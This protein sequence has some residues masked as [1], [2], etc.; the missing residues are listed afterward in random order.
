[1]PKT[2]FSNSQLPQSQS[3]PKF[4]LSGFLVGNS[5]VTVAKLYSPLYL[6][7]QYIKSAMLKAQSPKNGP[8]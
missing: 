7:L 2:Y 6:K 5:R 1:M 3:C 8:R 4:F